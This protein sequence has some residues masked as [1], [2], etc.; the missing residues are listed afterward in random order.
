M[1]NFLNITWL[2]KKNSAAILIFLLFSSK[3]S[4]GQFYEYGQ[5]PSSLKWEKIE[6]EHFRIIYPEEIAREATRVL[7]ILEKQYYQ[8]SHQ[9]GHEPRKIPIVLHNQTVRSNGFVVWAPKRSEFFMTPDTDPNTLEWST[10]LSIHEFR[11]VVQLDKLDQGF[12]RFL[13][14]I[15]GEQGIGPAAATLPFWFY[16][17]DAVYAETSLSESGRGRSPEFEMGIKANLFEDKKPWSYTKSYLGSIKDY[18]PTYYEYGYQMVSYGREKFGKDFWSEAIKYSGRK[19]FLINP[20]FFYLKKETGKGKKAF[21]D[22]TINYIKDHWEQERE[23]RSF[24]PYESLNRTDKKNFTSYNYPQFTEDLSIIAIKSGLDIIDRFVSIDSMGNEELIY[25]PGRLNSGRMSYSKK[26]IIWDEFQPDIR[27]TNRSFSNIIE[28]N[29]ENGQKRILTR[30]SRYSSPSFSYS[31]DSI[32]AIETTLSNDFN[33]IFISALDGGVFNRVPSPGNV[34]LLEPAWI[35]KSDEILVIGLDREGKKLMKYDRS[36][37]LWDEILWTSEIN[38][39]NPVSTGD[40]IIFNGSFNGVDN[41]YAFKKNEGKLY[42]ITSSEFG[43]FEPDITAE[44]DFLAFADYSAKGYDI[45]TLKIEPESFKP[46]LNK[47]ITEQTFFRY[48]DADPELK[49]VVKPEVNISAKPEKYSKL[50]NLFKFHSWAPF[51]F[52]YTDPD[53]ENPAINPG[54]TLLSQ[55]LL[56]TAVSSVG[57]EY[58]EGEHFFHTSFTYKGWLPVIDLSYNFGGLPTVIDYED[59]PRPEKLSTGS[60]FRLNTYI[61]L[62]LYSGKWISG[63]QPSLRMSYYNDYFYYKEDGGYKK[64]ITYAEP[65]LYFYTF[66]RTALMDFQPRW[67]FILDL[68]GISTPFENE[69]RGSNRAIKTTLYLPGIIRGQGLKLKAEWQ[70]QEPERYLFGNLLTFPRGYEPR[71]SSSINKFSADYYLP[72]LYPDLNLPGVLYLKRVRANLFADYLYGEEM[73]NYSNGELTMETGS[74]SSLGVELNL[75]YHLFRILVPFASGVRASYLNNTGEYTFEFL[76][77]I[78]LD[79]F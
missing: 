73:R 76:F 59:V 22:S 28:Y 74:Y 26:R 37:G 15:L 19:P 43:A 58:N 52:D 25:I 40:Y 1:N 32:V 48:G 54:I 36:T 68:Q 63:F 9:L 24:D 69:Q 29:I 51:Y 60:N 46:S 66:Q 13:T 55:N 12:T 30:N 75:D 34:Q 33:L 61:P 41:I 31:G 64:G 47:A 79:R 21:Y 14:T 39:S 67:G 18:V 7:Y 42:R 62:V 72:L 11:H 4:S 5:S 10:L 20:L 35:A 2:T 3:F 45:I 8:N 38:I 53:L 27:W 70:D 57:Y 50:A 71:I 44:G 17:G 16:E 65:R 78:F 23:K 56:T 6:S 77:N 49:P